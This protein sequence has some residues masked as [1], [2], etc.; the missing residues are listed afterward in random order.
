MSGLQS[1]VHEV[2]PLAP[3]VRFEDGRFQQ[4]EDGLAAWQVNE[5]RQDQF[6]V[7]EGFLPLD[8]IVFMGHHMCGLNQRQ[9]EQTNRTLNQHLDHLSIY[10]ELPQMPE[11]FYHTLLVTKA[12]SQCPNWARLI[13]KTGRVASIV[14]ILEHPQVFQPCPEMDPKRN[15]QSQFG[16]LPGFIDLPQDPGIPVR[17]CFEIIQ[18]LAW[19]DLECARQAVVAGIFEVSKR[20]MCRAEAK[21]GYLFH[22]VQAAQVECM[23]SVEARIFKAMFYYFD[24]PHLIL[25]QTPSFSVVLL[26]LFK[27]RQLDPPC[28]RV[29]LLKILKCVFITGLASMFQ[30]IFG[31]QSPRFSTLV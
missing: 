30:S 6:P 9:A 28:S 17:L 3:T 24:L 22:I 18:E 25:W 31:Y 4:V 20:V 14:E 2:W 5:A 16:L 26:K 29:S 11:G 1:E 8:E 19:K 21:G 7:S 23:R 12:L 27:W 10:W 15:L 13:G